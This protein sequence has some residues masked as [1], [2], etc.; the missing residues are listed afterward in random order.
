MSIKG[1]AW[2]ICILHATCARHVRVK[3]KSYEIEAINNSYTIFRCFFDFGKK[4]NKY[5]FKNID[6]HWKHER[7]LKF[8]HN[9]FAHDLHEIFQNFLRLKFWELNISFAR[10][11]KSQNKLDHRAEN[12][13][14]FNYMFRTPLWQ[15][16]C[17]IHAKYR[18]SMPFF[19]LTFIDNKFYRLHQLTFHELMSLIAINLAY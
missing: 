11:S 16:S 2:K 1:K 19:L 12:V 13:I 17:K 6:V 14:S 15:V 18:F 4:P 3:F 9:L 5:L 8:N 10:L 7:F